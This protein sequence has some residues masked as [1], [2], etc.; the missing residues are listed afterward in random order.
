[1]VVRKARMP[2]S[3]HRRLAIIDLSAAAQ[4]PMT[5][6]GP[7]VITYNGEIYNY[8]ELREALGGALALSLGF[9]HRMHSRRL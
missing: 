6:P 7:T 3:S 1:M 9:R 5:A 4:Q 8:L 2:A